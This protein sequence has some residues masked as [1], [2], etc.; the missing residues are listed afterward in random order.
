[1]DEAVVA[2]HG[3]LHVV[4]GVLRG[5]DG[6]ILLAQRPPGKSL[7]GLWE[8]P[9]GKCEDGELPIDA[10]ARELREELGVVVESAHPLIGIPH[11]AQGRPMRLDVW[12][13][14]SW[15]GEPHGCEGQRLAWVDIADL[16]RV[17]MPPA[18]RPVATALR[19][20]SRYLITPPCPPQSASAIVRGV[21]LQ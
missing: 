20:P 11:E 1:M 13:V 12:N 14:S 5:A 3:L 2:Q 17:E 10:L 15:S 21:E 8:Y 18:D 9:G 19:L 7:A 6:R 4:A 16:D